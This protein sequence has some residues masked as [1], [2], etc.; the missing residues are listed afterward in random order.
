VRKYTNRAVRRTTT[1]LAASAV[2]VA[3]CGGSGDGDDRASDAD[4]PEQT[5]VEPEPESDAASEPG[6]S[7]DQE[8]APAE[9]PE[10]ESDPE[11]AADP[12]SGD[13]ADWTVLVYI[14]GDNDLEPFAV[15]D[16]L[17]MNEITPSDRVNVIA[18]ADRHPEYTLDDDPLGDFATTR[19]FRVSSDGGLEAAPDEDEVNVGDPDVLAEFIAQGITT[20]PAERYAVVLWNHGAGWPGMGPD[21]TDGN[22]ILDLADI[23]QAFEQGLAAAGVDQVD[24][25][26]F[27]ACLMASYEV[28]SVM[29]DHARYMLASAELEP[30]HGWNYMALDALSANP[31]VSTVELGNAIIDGFVG[32]A[33]EAG[34]DEQITLSLVDLTRMAELEGAL[35][36]LTEPLL[37]EPELAAPLL[38]QAQADALKFGANPDPSID[39]FHVD[40]GQVVT[41]LGERDPVLAEPAATV[42]DLIDEMVVSKVDG[43]ATRGATGLS[44]YFPPFADTF[45]Q[46]YLNLQGVEVWPD[47]LTSFYTAGAAIPEEEQVQFTNTNGEGEYFFDED[48]LNLFGFFDTVAENNVVEAEI[49]YGVLDESDGSIIYIGEEPGEFSTDGSGLAAAIYDLTVLTISDGIDTDYAYLDLGIDRESGVATIDVP[50]WY[51]PPEEFDTDDPPRDVLLSLVLDLDFNILSETYYRIDENG[52]AGELAADPNGLIFPVVLN[53][54]PDGTTEW[55]TLSERGLFANLPDLVYDLEPLE[56]GTGLYAELVIRD[57]GG[58]TSAVSMFDTIPG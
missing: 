1:L 6:D 50:L 11:P 14:M 12:G 45:R 31:D 58:N 23:D 28:A 43:V 8:P 54:Y 30:G 37:A 26:G 2:L 44:I 47:L 9:E 49:F 16:L 4:E 24:L 41:T 34:T 17:E 33:Q 55:L 52:I 13:I 21:E 39:S 10:P 7:S 19:L 27:D 5:E 57:Y 3:A 20:A 56:A 22:D 48:G 35:G 51:V 18:L 15:D 42:S 32:Q 29:D 25:V 46:G 38:A 36:S 40:L 53:E